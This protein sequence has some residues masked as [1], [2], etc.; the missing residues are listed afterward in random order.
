MTGFT[1][2]GQAT[3]VVDTSNGDIEISG[4]YSE[5][6]SVVVNAHLHGLT[7]PNNPTAS[8]IFPLNFDSATAGNFNGMSTL[9]PE[10]LAGLLA[11]RTYINVHTSNNG[12][13]EIRGNLIPE[14]STVALLILGTLSCTAWAHRRRKRAARKG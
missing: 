3:V 10:N 12:P 8:P 11:G 1:P 14:P 13:G 5:M 7:D 4:S 6:T 9:S 2:Q